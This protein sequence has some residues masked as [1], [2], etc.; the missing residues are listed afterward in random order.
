M[1]ATDLLLI[2][3]VDRNPAIVL[4]HHHH[5]QSSRRHKVR[6]VELGDVAG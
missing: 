3:T 5:P 4:L 2:A 6:L 1:I